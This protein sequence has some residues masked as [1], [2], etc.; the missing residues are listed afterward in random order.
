[1]S[2]K[3]ESIFLSSLTLCWLSMGPIFPLPPRS[4]GRIS[5][6]KSVS[7]ED[8]LLECQDITWY[9]SWWWRHPRN[10]RQHCPWHCHSGMV[11]A[12]R[13]ACWTLWIEILLWNVKDHNTWYLGAWRTWDCLSHRGKEMLKKL[14]R[15]LPSS[16]PIALIY[17][18]QNTSTS[19]KSSQQL[20]L[21]EA[22]PS[23][24]RDADT[25]GYL[26]S[27]LLDDHLTEHVP[28]AE[29][30]QE[31]NLRSCALFRLNIGWLWSYLVWVPPTRPEYIDPASLLVPE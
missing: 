8:D 15:F 19:G 14:A 18:L 7:Y 16:K 3:K 12:W 4:E 20:H 9:S 10:E 17:K 26:S 21:L 22:K 31:G 2:W 28:H 25:A 30:V 27:L 13:R 5:P 23:G 1:M 29:Q 6:L 11:W 24:I